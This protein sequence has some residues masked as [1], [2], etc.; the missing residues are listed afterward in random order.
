[1]E[2]IEIEIIKLGVFARSAIYLRALL[3]ALVTR[4]AGKSK[5]QRKWR[6][7][8][9]TMERF[10]TTQSSLSLNVQ[11]GR[12]VPFDWYACTAA[13]W[14]APHGVG[15]MTRRLNVTPGGCLFYD[16]DKEGYTVIGAKAIA[17]NYEVIQKQSLGLDEYNLSASDGRNRRKENPG[18]AAEFGWF[19]T[20][21]SLTMRKI[22][23][24]WCVSVSHASLKLAVLSTRTPSTISEPPLR[25]NILP[26]STAFA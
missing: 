10:P 11:R 20:R 13:R 21:C 22:N 8:N 23:I 26:S 14:Q 15:S 19:D 18:A 9:R 12:K 17:A 6:L 2:N 16:Q 4:V 1:M 24:A 7:Q 3:L 5:S 25:F